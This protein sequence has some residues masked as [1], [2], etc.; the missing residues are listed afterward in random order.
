MP[1]RR[2]KSLAFFVI[3]ALVVPAWLAGSPLAASPPLDKQIF[4]EARFERGELKYI[5][6]LPVLIVQ[7]TPAEIGRQ[8]AVLTAD[9]LKAVSDYPKRLLEL[10]GR[11]QQWPQFVAMAERLWPQSSLEHREELQAFMEQS[12]TDRGV[13]LVGNMIMDLHR[14]TFACSSLIVE[15][16]KSATKQPL[17]G[18]N[19]DFYPLGLLDKHGLVTVYR[20]KGKHAFVSIGFPGI[21][22]C[23]S[24]M[25]DAGLAL[26]VHEVYLAADGAPMFNPKGMPY[27]FCFRQILE[28]CA[29]VDDAQRLLRAT[30]RTTMLNLAVCDRHGGTVFELTPRT[31]AVRHGAGGICVCTNHF[32]TWE[33]A[34]WPFCH[35]YETLSRAAA[36]P[37]ITVADVAAKLDEANQERL[38]VQTMIFEPGPLVLHLAM[39]NCPSSKHPLERL[40]L[41]KL[42][43]QP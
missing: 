10:L 24:G 22:G 26:A 1:T 41:A 5:H 17:F 2:L 7:G 13:V 36:M 28:E 3:L 15:P 27:T 16:N 8:E 23:L 39:G 18:R 42:L 34:L 12:G 43:A 20:P 38:T 19:L 25:N 37:V 4:P 31:V 11:K 40:P 21:L 33:L 14:G 9:G 35:R 30:E 29:S 6:G 32:R